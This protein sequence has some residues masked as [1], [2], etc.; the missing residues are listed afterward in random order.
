MH[1]IANIHKDT[2]I[3]K[4]ED[5]LTISFPMAGLG[6]CFAFLSLWFI[7]CNLNISP[8]SIREAR[9]SGINYLISAELV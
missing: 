1:E 5:E 3:L 8:H 2:K 9:G 6:V 7:S 4:R